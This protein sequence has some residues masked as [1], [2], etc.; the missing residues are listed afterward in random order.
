[1]MP[2][3]GGLIEMT[4]WFE[5]HPTLDQT[6]STSGRAVRLTDAGAIRISTSAHVVR[7]TGKLFG[8]GVA[9]AVLGDERVHGIGSCR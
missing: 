7:A 9:R 5:S 3:P 8:V 4:L 1:M 2:S 6:C